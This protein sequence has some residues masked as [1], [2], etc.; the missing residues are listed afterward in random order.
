MTLSCS[1]CAAATATSSAQDETHLAHLRGLLRK[2]LGKNQGGK[3]GRTTRE[4]S[5]RGTAWHCTAGDAAL[6]LAMPLLALKSTKP[7]MGSLRRGVSAVLASLGAPL[8]LED[9]L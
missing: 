1:P 4:P 2:I 3:K 9:G 7:E 5:S 8:D 6:L